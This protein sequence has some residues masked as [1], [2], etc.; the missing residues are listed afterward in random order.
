MLLL[1]LGKC[2]WARGDATGAVKTSKQA[3]ETLQGLPRIPLTIM[4]AIEAISS[5]VV[6]LSNAGESVEYIE[7]FAK[8]STALILSVDVARASDD[9]RSFVFERAKSVRA[10]LKS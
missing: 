5:V 1:E 7:G 3:V 9:L 10:F 6:D 2:Y 4:L 8:M